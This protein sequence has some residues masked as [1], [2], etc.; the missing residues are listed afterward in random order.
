MLNCSDEAHRLLT[1]LCRAL[2]VQPLEGCLGKGVQSGGEAEAAFSH[3]SGVK[4][5]VE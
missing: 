3:V 5:V 2:S 1:D 4:R